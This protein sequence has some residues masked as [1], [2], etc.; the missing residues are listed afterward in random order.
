MSKHTV[1]F[2]H[3]FVGIWTA[4]V[5]QKN[6]KIHALAA[7]VVA[8]VAWYLGVSQN[9]ALTLILTVMLVIVAEMVNT[10]LEF[11]SDAVTLKKNP[12]IKKAKDVS[13]GAVLIAAL[14]AVLVGAVIFIPKIR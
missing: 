9:E 5:T 2:Y 1:S 6:L 3:A 12:F 13:A 10:S 11:M 4:F 8:I 14:F 7:S